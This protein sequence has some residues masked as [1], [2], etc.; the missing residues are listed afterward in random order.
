MAL[1]K[2][3]G[4]TLG[5][6]APLHKGHQWVIE[7]ALAEMEQV[8]I[9]IYPCPE[10]TLIPLSVR[11]DW[12]RQLYPQA[13]IIE[14]WGGPTEVGDT[15]TI[16]KAHEDYILHTLKLRGITHFYSNEFYGEHM[17]HA[18]GAI[19]RQ[20]DSSR[21]TIPISATQIRQHPYQHRA[22]VHPIVYRDLVTQVVFVG[23]PSTGKTT[24]AERMA[25]E[26][27]TVWMPEYGR[28]YW[29]QHQIKRRLSLRQLV[30]IAQQH[31]A[32]EDQ[33]LYQ[34]NRYLFS[35]T[36]AL[37]TAIFSMY[38]HGKVAKPLAQLASLAAQRYDLVFL[39][40][41][42]IPY[43]DTWDRSGDANRQ[44]FQ[45]QIRDDLLRRKIPFFSLTGDLENRVQ[46]VKNIL[47]KYH[48]F[49]NMLDLYPT[50][51]GDKVT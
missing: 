40:E 36:N 14:A 31:L 8:T 11:A 12:L 26:Y 3:H 35:D 28:E 27:N 10:V 33:L 38:Y 30:E 16:K 32:R 43:D 45:Q 47:S 34:A 13:H 9:L 17:S 21:Q 50:S 37:T 51:Y 20:L 5:K 19:N 15:P 4:L 49:Q 48:K 23:A 1:P 44:A 29:E 39:C 18:L 25:Q 6:Y 41:A 2:T 22:F 42:D 24:L 7:T 46:Q